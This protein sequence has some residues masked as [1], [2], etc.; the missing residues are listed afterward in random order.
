MDGGGERGMAGKQG[1]HIL[2]KLYH[3]VCLSMRSGASPYE[4]GHIVTHITLTLSLKR[5]M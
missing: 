4:T 2:V 1:A 5:S 3:I